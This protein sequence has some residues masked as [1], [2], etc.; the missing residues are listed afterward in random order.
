MFKIPQGFSTRAVHAGNEIDR[1][2]VTHAKTL[3]IYQTS[4]FVYDSLA[5]VDD[6][7]AGNPDNY[8]YT[9]IGNPNPAALEALILA[10]EGGEAALFGA[11]GMAAIGAALLGNLEAGDHLIASRELYGTTQSL[12]EKELGRL[13]IASS[14]VDIG[15]LAAVEAAI[16]P[17]TRLIYTETASNPLVRVSDVPAL[18]TLAKKH[19]L[20]LLVDNTFLSPALFRPLDHGADLVLHSTTKYLNG[21]SDATGGILAGD[22]EWVERARRFQ[23]NAGGSASP[24]EA[25]LTLRGAK[26]LALR[27]QAHSR[28]AQALA[29]ALEAHPKVLRVHYPGLPSHPDHALARRLF[30]DGCSGMLSFTLDGGLAEVDRLIRA[31]RLAVFAPSLAG[32]ATSISHP[33]KTSHRALAP[34][35]LAALDIHDGT[36]RVSVGIEEAGDIVDDFV[37]ALERL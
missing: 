15:D 26:T 20:K 33:G 2:M 36:V 25:W 8:M 7:L 16:G 32:V 19:G 18:A 17:R 21:H 6:F 9:R 37:Q 23:I 3:P 34:E 29:E 27:M 1:Q 28:N 35:V 4:V 12:I 24:F 31:L 13:G 10:L 5:Q 22:A 11:S 30:P 14:L